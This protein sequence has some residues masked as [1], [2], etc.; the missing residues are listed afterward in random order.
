MSGSRELAAGYM[1]RRDAS[2]NDVPIQESER[3]LSD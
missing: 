3:R 1:S 2:I